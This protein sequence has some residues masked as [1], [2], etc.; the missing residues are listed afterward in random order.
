MAL[1]TRQ[2]TRNATMRKIM[3]GIPLTVIHRVIARQPA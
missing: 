1:F 2:A 3:Y